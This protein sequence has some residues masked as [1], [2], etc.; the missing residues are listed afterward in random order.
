MSNPKTKGAFGRSKSE[1]RQVEQSPAAAAPLPLDI[2]TDIATE[3][4]IG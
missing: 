1:L 4:P 3:R 2:K